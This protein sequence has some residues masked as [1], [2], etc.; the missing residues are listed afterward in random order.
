MS[1]LADSIGSPN[2]IDPIT[3]PDGVH[4]GAA[5]HANAAKASL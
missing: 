5:A 1:G 3:E 2:E 4:T